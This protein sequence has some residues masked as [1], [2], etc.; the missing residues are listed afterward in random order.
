MS[1]NMIAAN[2]RVTGIIRQDRENQQLSKYSN[3]LRLK[4]LDKL[5]EKVSDAFFIFVSLLQKLLKKLNYNT[6]PLATHIKQ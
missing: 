2:C 6:N 3:N 5:R 4:N 1:V